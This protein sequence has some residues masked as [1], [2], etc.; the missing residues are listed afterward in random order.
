MTKNI[1]KL[2]RVKHYIKN[3]LLFF[4]LI[5][6]GQLFSFP[7]LAKVL[8]GFFAFSFS[9]SVIYIINDMNDV[10][11][12]RKHPT[13]CKR[14]LASGAIS[15]GRAKIILALLVVFA[16]V[17]NTIVARKDLA[18]CGILLLYIG[19]NLAYSFGAKNI[20][21]L[22]VVILMLGYV[23]RIYYGAL[24]IDTSVS[25]WLYLTVLSGAFFLGFGKRR[26]ELRNQG[27]FSRKVLQQYPPEFLDKAMYLCL[28]LTITFYALWC[29]AIVEATN[30][31]MLLL[32]IPLV[33]IICMRYIMNIEGTSDG[34]P[35]E[36]VLADKPLLFLGGVYTVM[37][38][39]ILYG[40]KL[41]Q[42]I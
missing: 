19:C 14:P 26:N 41:L 28:G 32:S 5:F 13:K 23:L 4:P 17:L 3:L 25:S 7:Q 10:E 9:A 27:S 33:I 38:A 39:I 24:L 11:N 8:I 31:S 15:S 35:I 29:E 21:L 37:M 2:L 40:E 16:I 42:W 22:D 18:I 12:D 34:D 1:I 30:N 20:A 6:S 36:V